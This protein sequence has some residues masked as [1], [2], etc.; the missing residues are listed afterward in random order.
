MP[1][2]TQKVPSPILSETRGLFVCTVIFMIVLGIRI[3]VLCS[4]D[5][6]SVHLLRLQNIQYQYYSAGLL[7]S[8]DRF[9]EHQKLIVG[10]KKKKEKKPEKKV[11]KIKK[12][13]APRNKSTPPENHKVHTRLSIIIVLAKV[14]LDRTINVV[15]LT[16]NLSF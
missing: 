9:L 5:C 8:Y 6:N 2:L 11:I 12:E 14:F 1:H 13:K 10:N 15:N 4:S 16:K 3:N 7:S